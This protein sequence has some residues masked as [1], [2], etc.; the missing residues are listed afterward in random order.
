M[1]AKRK[2]WVWQFARLSDDNKE[3]LCNICSASISYNQSTSAI[4]KHLRFFH[5]HDPEN[6]T[7]SVV[8]DNNG[9]A[10]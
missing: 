1:S 2:S 7:T 8:A 5:K 3:I 9:L 4:N 10:M 6:L